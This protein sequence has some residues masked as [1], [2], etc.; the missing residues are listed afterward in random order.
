MEGPWVF[1]LCD[2]SEARYFVAEKRDKQTLHD[3]IKREVV[4][5]SVIYSDG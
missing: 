1:G 4:L 5:G 3:I 2:D